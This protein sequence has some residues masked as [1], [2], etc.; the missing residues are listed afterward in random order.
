LIWGGLAY[1]AGAVTEFFRWPELLPGIVGPHEIFH[2]AVL[3]G[4]AWHW[5]FILGIASGEPRWA[6]ANG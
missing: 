1:T 5:A 6:V 4:I 2:L 3:A